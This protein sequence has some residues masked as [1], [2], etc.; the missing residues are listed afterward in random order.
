L[1]SNS[2][3][4]CTS[5]GSHFGAGSRDIGF[6][7]LRRRA[8]GAPVSPFQQGVEILPPLI[9]RVHGYQADLSLVQPDVLKRPQHTFFIHDTDD[10][11]HR[12]SSLRSDH[13]LFGACI[14]ES[15]REKNKVIGDRGSGSGR[16]RGA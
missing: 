5:F 11:P 2:A 12:V 14:P 13:T 1:E 3:A 6:D 10:A 15:Y 9:F 8:S 7:C 16:G 4:G